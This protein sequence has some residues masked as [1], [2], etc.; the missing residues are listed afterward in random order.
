MHCIIIGNGIAGI[1]A[2][3]FLRKR[4]DCRITVI[5]S[6]SPH[7][8]SRTALMYVYMGHM[9][10]RDILPYAND[11]WQKNRIDLVSD[12]IQHIDFGQKILKGVSETYQ[13]DKLILAPGSQPNRLGWPGEHLPGVQGLYH[14]QD[15]ES[16]ESRSPHINHAVIVGG[17]LI[18]IEMAEMFHSRHIP[19]TMLVRE[20]SY[21]SGV[22]PPEESTMVNREIRAHGIQL[23]LEDELQSIE[24]DDHTGVRGV[25]T[26][27]GEKIPCEFVGLTI[28]VTPNIGWLTASELETRRGILVDA[29][30]QT[31]LPD[32]YAVGDA[33][34]LR[35]PMPGRRAIEA[36][37]YTG[38]MMGETAAA[39]VL[40]AAIPYHPGTWFNSAK[41][42][43]IEYQVYGQVPVIFEE[44]DDFCYWEDPQRKRSIRLV[45]DRDSMAVKGFNLMGVR[46]RQ[47]VCVRWIE[48]ATPIDEVVRQLA[49]A[50]F[51]TAL[52]DNAVA[53]FQRH[54]YKETGR[55]VLPPSKGGLDRII[56]FLKS[57]KV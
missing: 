39:N 26:R 44:G 18:G 5:S 3:R 7:F 48:T 14:R 35:E 41:F 25:T 1:T 16:M 24:G 42:F 17:G 2:A 55:P 29:Y 11:F 23:I 10:W 51:D 33:A 46:F 56:K 13:Y 31:N 45:W 19:V 37:W 21:W 4:S 52:S 20:P 53:A 27:Q 8:F 43:T 15:L 9:R 50:H 57:S 32:V 34:E 40:G 54:Y 30:L 28:G 38:R 22:L 36:V 12:H 47:E 6:E 49:L